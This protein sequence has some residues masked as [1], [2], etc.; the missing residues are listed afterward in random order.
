MNASLH[1]ERYPGGEDATR[2]GVWEDDADI[3]KGRAIFDNGGGA[4]STKIEYVRAARPLLLHKITCFDLNAWTWSFSVC[5]TIVDHTR[6]ALATSTT[7]AYKRHYLPCNRSSTHNRKTYL[8][9]ESTI[10]SMHETKGDLGQA[11]LKRVSTST[12]TSPFP[13][14][15]GDKQYGPQKCV[16]DGSSRQHGAPFV[17]CI[18]P[19]LVVGLTP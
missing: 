7:A 3:I 2:R 19:S 6:T 9:C 8:V 14:K 10:F 11:L 17:V 5:S 4:G 16:S 12:S 1:S 13:A 18:W 15:K